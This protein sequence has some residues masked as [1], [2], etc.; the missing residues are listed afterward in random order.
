MIQPNQ[1]LNGYEQKWK[2]YDFSDRTFSAHVSLPLY[3]NTTTSITDDCFVL[4]AHLSITVPSNLPV[5]DLLGGYNQSS[6][7][8]LALLGRGGDDWQNATTTWSCRDDLNLSDQADDAFVNVVNPPFSQYF[9]FIENRDDGKCS[10]R[11]LLNRQ[12]LEDRDSLLEAEWQDWHDDCAKGQYDKDKQL[13]RSASIKVVNTVVLTETSQESDLIGAPSS[14]AS[15][16]AVETNCDF[17][18]SGVG[19]GYVICW[20]LKGLSGMLHFTESVVKSQL[21][22]EREDYEKPVNNQGGF[23]YKDAWRN[24]RDAATYAIVATAL[25]MVISTA[26]DAGF[27]K[28]YTVKKYLPRLVAGTILIQFSWVLGDFMIQSF[29]QLGDWLCKLCFSQLFQVPKSRV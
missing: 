13:K 4:E 23:T 12:S 28:N 9:I 27:F 20:I 3:N 17:H 14:I 5:F 10:S 24:M 29:T 8:G 25:F 22:I 6:C 18:L 19:F 1:P 16:P 2:S 21:T 15:I 7:A 26:L 11:I